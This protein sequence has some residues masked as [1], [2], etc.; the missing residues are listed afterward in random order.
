MIEPFVY[1]FELK[2]LKFELNTSIRCR[3]ASIEEKAIAGSGVGGLWTFQLLA[4]MG[5]LI[6]HTYLNT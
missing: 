1:Y 3:D 4:N 2:D 6:L 5:Q